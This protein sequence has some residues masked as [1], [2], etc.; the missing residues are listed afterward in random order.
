[1]T[2]P[3]P[4]PEPEP[5][6]GY[7][8]P[9]QV[10]EPAAP[11]TPTQPIPSQTPSQPTNQP[12]SGESWSTG[13]GLTEPGGNGTGGGAGKKRTGL[14]VGG[15]AAVLAIGAGGVLATQALSGGGAQP[16]EVLPGDSVLYLRLDIDPSAGQKVA[17]V[18]FLDK[19]PD[20]KGIAGDGDP[21]KKLWEMVTKE[22]ADDCVSKFSYDNDIAPW[23]GDRVGFSMRPGGTSRTPNIAIAI[24]VKDE[25]KA[26]DTIT[27]LFS[28]DSKDAGD[29]RMKNG[30]AILTP[31]GQGDATVAAIDKGTL[32]ANTTFAGD[33]SALGEQGVLSMWADGIPLVKELAN[34]GGSMGGVN[35]DDLA[36]ITE[37][38][39]GRVA[40]AVR[41]DPGYV[42][43]A[44]IA[45]GLDPSGTVQGD[46]S[47]LVN[48]PDDTALA[49]HSSG[50]DKTF[51]T[52]WAQFKKQIDS[53]T[54]SSGEDP[55]D[56]LESEYGIK[57]PDD[58]KALLGSS[59]TIAM[60]AQELG[61]DIPTIGAKVVSSNAQR[62]DEV[63]GTIE[64]LADASGTVTRKVEGNKLFVAT[65][66]DYVGA[67]QSGGKLG[68]SDAFKAAVTDVGQ[69]HMAVFVD[70]DKLGSQLAKEADG[71]AKAVIE[72]MKS[73]GISASFMGEGE[74]A[75]SF[76]IVGD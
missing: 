27:R 62:A 22:A 68:D 72:A 73:I 5:Q 14:I 37:T 31:P 40:A 4:G 24:Q 41:F 45:R 48:L 7:S 15:V 26:N 9:G 18:R 30:Y 69:A 36:T 10:P 42:E 76:K 49:I 70:M 64:D 1:M 32:A 17:A 21:R 6:P 13:V 2:Q 66:P 57:L 51:D 35:A 75:F 55:L 44:G 71:D 34:L 65:T 16:A 33:M 54:G 46:T 59:L 28:C 19:L 56:Q 3:M 53:A 39:Q 61:S 20:L 23:L 60:P 8:Y 25:S 50:H 47:E 12:I 43:L 38:A 74:Y 52:A 63:I 58:L 11:P 67:L 29:V